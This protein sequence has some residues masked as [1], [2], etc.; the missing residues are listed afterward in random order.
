MEV[1][2]AG[3]LKRYAS[4]LA[5]GPAHCAEGKLR[6]R[7]TRAARV[8]GRGCG[9]FGG[10]GRVLAHLGIRRRAPARRP[11]QGARAPRPRSCTRPSHTARARLPGRSAPS[12]PAPRAHSPPAADAGRSG[13][14]APAASWPL[15]CRRPQAGRLTCTPPSVP[16]RHF[17]RALR[18]R[19]LYFRLLFGAGGGGPRGLPGFVVSSPEGAGPAP[20][21]ERGGARRAGRPPIGRGVVRPG[22]AP[23]PLRFE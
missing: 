17:P 18:P 12:L 6:P 13:E 11:E 10:P 9:S 23:G 8:G 20:M 21:G 5:S 1:T 2:G 7:G 14:A 16:A 22:P 3:I 19:A 15:P 4:D